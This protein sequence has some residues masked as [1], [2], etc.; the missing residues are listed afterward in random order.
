MC[1]TI[2]SE[3]FFQTSK[4]G[5]PTLYRIHQNFF[6]F[7]CALF[8]NSSISNSQ[9]VRTLRLGLQGRIQ[10]RLLL[11]WNLQR[12]T[13]LL[14][15]KLCSFTDIEDRVAVLV[16][17]VRGFRNGEKAFTSRAEVFD[18]ATVMRSHHSDDKQKD[19]RDPKR[20]GEVDIHWNWMHSELSLIMPVA[21]SYL[22]IVFEGSPGPDLVVHLS[23]NAQDSLYDDGAGRN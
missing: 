23:R 17:A 6:I 19:T 22:M 15:S 10:Y 20:R 2:A 12:L 11:L 1:S 5:S 9:L 7:R 18:S 3:I 16:E 21:L 13:A 8:F 4:A 14:P